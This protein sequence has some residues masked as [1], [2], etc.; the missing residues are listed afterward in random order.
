MLQAQ[1]A[2]DRRFGR[3]WARATRASSEPGGSPWGRRGGSATAR[4]GRGSA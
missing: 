1:P 2:L 4:G 3:G